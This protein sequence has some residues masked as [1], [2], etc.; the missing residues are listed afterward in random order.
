MPRQEEREAITPVEEGRPA[1]PGALDQP[2]CAPATEDRHGRRPQGYDAAPVGRRSSRALAARQSRSSGNASANACL[3]SDP[4]NVLALNCGSSS[5]KFQVFASDPGAL[6][7]AVRRLARGLVERIGDAASLAFQA[8]GSPATHES[9][10]GPGPR[11]CSSPSARMA[12][13]GRCVG[14]RRS[15]PDRR[16]RTSRGPRGRALHGVRS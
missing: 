14:A 5:L 3:P 12:C 13:R 11:G 7:A 15:D 10:A 2:P 1:A 9:D 8:E 16:G 6:P 4:V